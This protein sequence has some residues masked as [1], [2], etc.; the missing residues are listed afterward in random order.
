MHCG[1]KVILQSSLKQKVEID[2]SKVFNNWI[3]LGIMASNSENYSSAERYAEKILEQDTESGLGWFILAVASSKNNDRCWEAYDNFEKAALYMSYDERIERGP[4]FVSHLAASVNVEIG[5]EKKSSDCEFDNNSVKA[6]IDKESEIL[7]IL[8][9]DLSGLE[10]I[11][12]LEDLFDHANDAHWTL[13]WEAMMLIARNCSNG[14]AAVFGWAND[15]REMELCLNAISMAKKRKDLPVYLPINKKFIKDVSNILYGNIENN[16]S[17]VEKADRWW[18]DDSDFNE[19]DPN[20]IKIMEAKSDA[21]SLYEDILGKYISAKE[22]QIDRS[23]AK[24]VIGDERKERV[25][26]EAYTKE[27]NNARAAAVSRMPEVWDMIID[28]T[29]RYGVHQ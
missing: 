26:K 4:A 21:Y 12:L 25:I 11:E 19:D 2:H 15:H 16:K 1:S 7:D 13:C 18:N 14:S 8:F 3:N 17:K 22:I 29:I 24:W 28:A 6:S 23:I 27:V 5:L 10:R 20:F 9:R